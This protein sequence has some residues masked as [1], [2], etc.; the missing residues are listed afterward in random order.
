MEQNIIEGIIYAEQ[1]FPKSFSNVN[2]TDYGMLFYNES[3]PESND[4]NHAII[5]NIRDNNYDEILNEVISF[6]ESKKVSPRIF[7]SLLSG[8]LLKIKKSLICNGF[9]VNTHKE[10]CLIHKSRC[11]INEPRS[12]KIKR[13]IDKNE[14]S[15]ISNVIDSDA[16][17]RETKVL[18]KRIKNNNFHYFIGYDN[19][20]PVT[21]ASIEYINGIGRID[22]VETSKLHRGKGYSRQLI[23]FL[24]DYHYRNI[25]NKKT[26][27]LWY[28]NPTAG[29]IYRE[30]G[31]IELDHNF[32]Q[33][34][35][36]IK[37][38]ESGVYF[39]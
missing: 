21:I 37:K 11:M 10:F 5:N 14:L 20:I 8:Q 27:Y 4:S 1:N 30:A 32:E 39:A 31:F 29:R 3:I 26:M 19:D 18:Q 12:L 33:W 38:G 34:E 2:Y 7:S 24:V 22:E 36:S 17:D 13:I 6:Y 23:R 35:A 28:S 16:V 25:D 9:T 15:V